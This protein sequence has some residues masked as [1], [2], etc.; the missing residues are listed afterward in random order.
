MLIVSKWNYSLHPSQQF[1]SQVEMGLLGF[2]QYKAADEVPC[3]RTQH[4]NSSRGETQTS[5]PA[6]PSLTLYQLSYWTSHQYG[7]ENPSE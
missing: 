5:N 7:R 3:S 1:F 2:S 6:I 4:H